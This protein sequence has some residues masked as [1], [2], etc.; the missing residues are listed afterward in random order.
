MRVQ[1]ERP[2]AVK[3][4]SA[5]LLITFYLH[6]RC[7]TASDLP[8]LPTSAFWLQLSGPISTPISEDFHFLQL[9]MT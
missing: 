4:T 5:W 3:L 9:L 2:V 1:R 7:A 6:I 8:A